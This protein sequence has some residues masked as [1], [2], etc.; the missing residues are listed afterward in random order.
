VRPLLNPLGV[1][2]ISHMGWR[3]SFHPM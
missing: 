2:G 3:T 1:E